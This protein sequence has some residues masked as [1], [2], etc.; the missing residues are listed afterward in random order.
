VFSVA[1]AVGLLISIFL[2]TC[3]TVCIMHTA[4]VHT[5]RPLACGHCPASFMLPFSCHRRQHNSRQWRWART[6]CVADAADWLRQRTAGLVGRW[7]PQ[8]GEWDSAGLGTNTQLGLPYLEAPCAM[9][10][11]VVL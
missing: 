7:S 1:P 9:C 8:P 2:G 10:C 6:H 5:W 4:I 11:L 3:T